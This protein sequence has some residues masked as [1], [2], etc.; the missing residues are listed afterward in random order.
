MS[1][2]DI[3]TCLTTKGVNQLRQ[4]NLNNDKINKVYIS[5]TCI[6][7]LCNFPSVRKWV[8]TMNVPP[9][10]SL[11]CVFRCFHPLY[12]SAVLPPLLCVCVC[13]RGSYG[14]LCC[15]PC[16]AFAYSRMIIVVGD[17]QNEG[18]NEWMNWL[19]E[20]LTINQLLTNR[21]TE[22]LRDGLNE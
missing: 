11:H 8:I 21:L 18:M 5:P 20:C 3:K 22:R 1:R 7:H 14:M 4:Q 9:L 2:I 10:N 17:W 19:N 12:S 13:Y 16:V 15:S 6:N